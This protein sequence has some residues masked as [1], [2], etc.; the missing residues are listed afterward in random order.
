MLPYVLSTCLSTMSEL[1]KTVLCKGTTA[2]TPDQQ[3][4]TLPKLEGG[5]PW[6]SAMSVDAWKC[7]GT[8]LLSGPKCRSCLV[9]SSSTWSFG[10]WNATVADRLFHHCIEKR[11][12]L[13]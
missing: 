5:G 1:S 3:C 12:A 6:S 13:V 10:F 2:T 4:P 9:K 8:F 7:G 11:W